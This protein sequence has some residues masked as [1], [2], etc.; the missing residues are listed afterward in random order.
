MI[1]SVIV[2]A[3]VYL[4][5]QAVAVPGVRF[6][7]LPFPVDDRVSRQ[8]KDGKKFFLILAI[9]GTLLS[10]AGVKKI[11]LDLDLD[12]GV[13]SDLEDLEAVEHMYE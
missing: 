2:C 11:S 4:F 13:V 10:S 8:R 12:A 6:P 9:T 1:E 3:W 5:R 7:G